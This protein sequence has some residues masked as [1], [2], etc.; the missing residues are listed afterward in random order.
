MGGACTGGGYIAPGAAPM[1]APKPAPV[2]AP[3]KVKKPPEE[4]ENETMAPA[5]ATILVSLPADAT[6]TVDGIKTVS[7]SAKR[8]F[9]SPVLQHGKTYS[10]SLTAEVVR[11]G[12]TVK[13][14]Q[15]VQVRAGEETNVTIELPVAVAAK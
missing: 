6:L 7:T 14:S 4:K 5:P 13:V 9:V 3:E 10:Y 11:D 12:K 2:K 15:D 1:P 8:T